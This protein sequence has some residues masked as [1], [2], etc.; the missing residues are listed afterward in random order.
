VLHFLYGHNSVPVL[1]HSH[2]SHCWAETLALLK[3]VAL[4]K[5]FGVI[6]ASIQVSITSIAAFLSQLP[7]TAAMCL[8]S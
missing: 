5:D 3:R 7:Q 1:L 6:S 2:L 8:H 4:T